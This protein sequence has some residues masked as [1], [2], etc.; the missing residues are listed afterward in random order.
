VI[1][2]FFWSNPT[3]LANLTLSLKQIKTPDK[4]NPLNYNVCA[5]GSDA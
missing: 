3:V 1:F 2:F 5:P 4:A